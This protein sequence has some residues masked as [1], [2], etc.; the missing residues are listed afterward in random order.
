LLTLSTLLKINEKT[1]NKA[2]KVIKD[3][4]ELTSSL[5]SAIKEIALASIWTKLA[6]KGVSNI[7]N[8]LDK[9][10]IFSIK[11]AENK[12]IIKEATKTAKNITAL[13]GYLLISSIFLSIE[14][15]VGI[16]ALLGAKF[17]NT[18]VDIITPTAQKLAENKKHISKAVT[19]SALLVTFTGIMSVASLALATI[20]V[21]GIPAL[22]GSAFLIGI[23]SLNV[24]TFKM[25]NKAKKNIVAGSIVMALMSTS[26]IL[27]GISLKKITDATKNVSWKQVAIIGTSLLTLALATAVLGIPAV[28]PF[29][30]LGAI[31]LSILSIG[32]LIYSTAL[33]KM[34]NATKDLKMKQVLAIGASIVSIG[35]PVALLG[36]LSIPIALGSVILGTMSFSL[37]TFAKSLKLINE[38]GSPTKTVNQ[39]LGA[40]KNVRDFFVENSL[41]INIVRRAKRYGKIM[42]PFA[43][44]AKRLSKLK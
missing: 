37:Y 9:L 31:S 2:N 10:T 42:K 19:T 28:A 21:T 41:K 18:L 17:L 11:L 38:L 34:T 15:V 20:A 36:A 3:I 30:A 29:I 23:V 27:Y 22:I 12:K 24:I 33:G 7:E 16:P 39:L 6:N 1:F 35:L 25:L 43:E 32:L 26:L 13:T 40:M 5:K 4:K 44:T 8:I 14:A